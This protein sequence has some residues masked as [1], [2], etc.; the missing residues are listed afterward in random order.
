MEINS[1]IN[2]FQ[3]GLNLDTD[4][5][6]LPEGQYR[7]AENIRLLTDA[8]GT[9]GMLQNIEY[10]R[11]YNG[12]IP[13]DEII[14]GTSNT[15]LSVKE[16]NTL[17]EV[18]V[19]LTKKTKNNKTYNTLYIVEGFES[20]NTVTTP[21]VKGYLKLENNVSIVCNYE[22]NNASNVYISDGLTAIKVIN[23]E[24]QLKLIDDANGVITEVIDSTKFDIIPGA[25]LVPFKFVSKIDGALPAGAIQYCYQLFNLHG[26]E[27]ATAALSE[28]IPITNIASSSKDTLGENNGVITNMGC[29]IQTSFKNDGRFDK[30]RIFAIVYLDNT[31]VPDVYIANEI[32][33][34]NTTENEF[35]TFTYNDTGNSYLSKITID[36]F[37]SYIP[38][39]FNAKSIE[40]LGNRLFASNVQELTWDI[41]F[42]ARAY[43]CNS[44]GRIELQSADV[45]KNISGY[46]GTDGKIYSD[47]SHTSEITVED[48][49]DC[50]N[51]TN[52][53]I[54]TNDS[55]YTYGYDS[56]GTLVRGGSGPNVSYRFI[57]TALNLSN[58]VTSDN[59]PVANFY[60]DQVPQGYQSLVTYYDNGSVCKTTAFGSEGAII[61]NYSDPY[62]CANFLGY[63]RDE[64][65][66]FGIILYNNKNI[67]SPVHWIGDIR[68]PATYYTTDTSDMV[69]PF[70]CGKTAGNF[71]GTLEMS[72]YALGVEFTVK[73]IPSDVVAY[74][75]VR[76]DRTQV[77]RT[78]VMQGA[79]SATVYFKQS[80][81]NYGTSD[82]RPLPVLALPKDRFLT[83]CGGE[84]HF[85]EAYPT[86][87]DCFEFVSPEVAISKDTI[88]SLI[89][90]SYLNP[91]YY[92]YSWFNSTTADTGLSVGLQADRVYDLDG[93]KALDNTF[94]DPAYS[95]IFISDEDV[96]GA[97]AGTSFFD[98][99]YLEK[100]HGDTV[101]DGK[102]IVCKYYAKEGT[103][104]LPNQY[105]SCY[106]I[107]DS[108]V[109]RILP[110][111]MTIEDT[112]SYVQFIG[113]YGYVNES[114]LINKYSAHH[115][116]SA[117]ILAEG[118]NPFISL[119]TNNTG[120]GRKMNEFNT[121]AICNIKRSIVPY[122]GNSYINRQNSIYQSCGCFKTN[123]DSLDS[124][125]TPAICYGG[126]TYLNLF[127]Y[128]N[129]TIRQNQ[130]QTT[131]YVENR[132]CVVSYIPLESAANTALRSDESF[133]KTTTAKIGQNL[134]QNEPTSM[135][136]YTQKTPLYVYN[137]VYSVT[138]GSK[139]YLP[140]SIYAED[141]VVTNTR[142]VCSELKTNNELTDSWSKFK[143]ANYL[144]VDTKYGEITNLK[145]FGN[146][147]YFWQANAVG[148]ASVNERSLITDNN[149]AELTLGTG[150]IL[151][152]FDYVAILNG[153][154][155]VNDKSITHSA[156]TL[157]WYDFDKNEICA[158]G[159]GVLP[160][161][162][163][164]SVQSYLNT[165]PRSAKKNAVSFYDKKYNEVW[166]RIYDR[167]LVYNEQLQ[168]FTSFYT[169]NPNWFFPFS[170]KLVT[171][172]DNNM[173]Y[174]HNIYEVN[175]NTKE[176]RISKVQF[177]V[178]KDVS[179]TK[180]FDNVTFSAELLDNDNT[181][182]NI[183]KDVVFKTKTQE[184][185][186][187]D[188]NSIELRED[189]YRFPISREKVDNENLNQ[190]ASQS[191]L[192][193]MRGKYLICDYTF[194]CNNNREFKLPYI[195]T[196]YRYSML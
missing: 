187:I 81:Y 64:I 120:V 161:S 115:G 129:T 32:D 17:K 171:I 105:T 84:K 106:K 21:I 42:D 136:A 112:K 118:V 181:N 148:I 61:P 45:T 80:Q 155:I 169:H 77:D 100:Y 24:E 194:D 20:I 1:Q 78:V 9:T 35:V 163:T 40:S 66:R 83:K 184:T 111:Q 99:G 43:R 167:A 18:G 166:F 110:L 173:Y 10:I 178:N 182:P 50:V 16:S 177:V 186:A 74:E 75:I 195:K 88:N 140:K 2:T 5:T 72:A 93:S 144:D 98:A 90:D 174:L 193:R 67:P 141:D 189:N 7:H 68:M 76:C 114:I 162:K 145:A 159:N 4:I 154:S 69:Y 92:N 133:S 142:I 143:F 138:S 55:T 30:A 94:S 79:L 39:E 124:M 95:N 192:G 33:I 183:I 53:R 151:T 131:E 125:S 48:S 180:V 104:T 134:I 196:T 15:L 153:S 87:K 47:S 14:I 103:N 59:T 126:D 188:F 147:L 62:I 156:T 38:Y 36:E 65:Y 107:E 158:L 19:V 176:E 191:Y 152:R 150:G 165:L 52:A 101:V 58:Q 137:P 70:H 56:N 164:K 3:K 172:K 117:I 34:P 82:T 122:G 63:Q 60:M 121:T 46:L 130:N 160:L 26:V 119:S 135:A 29:Q 127:D 168:V 116:T 102:M 157:Y 149:M 23:I 31:Q 49:H 11:Q 170:D 97:P 71:S 85:Y 96:S 37:N 108:I 175:S 190:L 12:G 27:T 8:D 86:R 44:S 113:N 146:K 25:T 109:T 28:V 57:Y 73:N 132:L 123:L 179:N 13:S 91:L 89:K 54:T 22:S 185:E 6:M 139:H 128:Q 41:D 51:P